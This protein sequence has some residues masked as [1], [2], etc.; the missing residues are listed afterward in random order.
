MRTTGQPLHLN[1]KHNWVYCLENYEPA[2]EEDTL[3]RIVEQYKQGASMKW[4]AKR[5]RRV[6][7]EIFLAL[8]DQACKGR[9]LP[10]CAFW[11]EGQLDETE[12]YIEEIHSEEPFDWGEEKEFVKV[13][14]T[15]ECLGSINKKTHIVEKKD[16]EQTKKRGYYMG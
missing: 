6:W 11:S 3:K 7:Q 10:P 1:P 15:T 2:F 16:W 9:V 14:I 13:V 8:F 12:I 4:I 5:E